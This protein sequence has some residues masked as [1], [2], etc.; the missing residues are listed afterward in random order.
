MS[1]GSGAAIIG[2]C[3]MFGQCARHEAVVMGAVLFGLVSLVVAISEVCR[4]SRH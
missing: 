3:L 2:A 1:G 4:G